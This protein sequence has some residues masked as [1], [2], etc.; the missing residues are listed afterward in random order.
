MLKYNSIYIFL[1]AVFKPF[2]LH[3]W[4]HLFVL[5]DSWLCSPSWIRLYVNYYKILVI[6]KLFIIILKCYTHESWQIKFSM[7]FCWCMYVW[8]N[9]GWTE[10][11]KMLEDGELGIRLA[12]KSLVV[13]VCISNT[14]DV[15]GFSDFTIYTILTSSVFDTIIKHNVLTNRL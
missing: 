6:L 7:E 15:I 13:C 1:I 12:N 3:L 2:L 5:E 11:G 8:E 14:R 10:E 9:E 4:S